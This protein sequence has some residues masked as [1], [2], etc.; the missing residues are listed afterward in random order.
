MKSAG[1]PRLPTG[2]S[3]ARVA[4]VIAH[5]ET[6]SEEDAVAEDEAALSDPGQTVMVIPTRLVPAVRELLASSSTYAYASALRA[7]VDKY[8]FPTVTYDFEKEQEV[9]HADMVGVETY[10]GIQLRAQGPKVVEYGLANVLYWGYANSPGRRA[11]R[12]ERFVKNVTEREI[13]DFISV[14]GPNNTP[15]LLEIRRIGLPEFGGLSFVS[16]IMMFLDPQRYPVLD[17]KIAESFSQAA[18]FPPLEGLVFRKRVDFGKRA[19][20]QI[21][22]NRKNES[23]YEIWASWCRDT[24]ASVNAE[25]G[26]SE[27]GIR[28]V[29]VERAMFALADSCDRTEAWRLLRGPCDEGRADQV[30]DAETAE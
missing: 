9:C 18:E 21:K 2:W 23:V 12:V 6:Q 8:R 20:T 29:D 28:A 16:K 30:R 3:G 1:N 22:I 7:A 27:K 10:I 24:A 5:Y 26:S 19:D 13:N 14:T 17:M 11:H 25:S 15:G 4:E